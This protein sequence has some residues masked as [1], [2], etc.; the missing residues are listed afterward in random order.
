MNRRD[1]FAFSGVSI[2]D[3]ANVD[4]K[5]NDL[6]VQVENFSLQFEDKLETILAEV[7]DRSQAYKSQLNVV[8]EGVSRHSQRLDV[9]ELRHAFVFVWLL[10]LTLI[11]GLDFITST[12]SL[13]W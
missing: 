7:R 10:S 13:I 2:I 9:M 12:I 1:F 8:S 11:T 4:G 6:L 5:Y 3:A